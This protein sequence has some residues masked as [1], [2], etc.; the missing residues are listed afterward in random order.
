[1]GRTGS[2]TTSVGHATLDTS[3]ERTHHTPET[4]DETPRTT[5]SHPTPAAQDLTLRFTCPR[6]PYDARLPRTNRAPWGQVQAF[7]RPRSCDVRRQIESDPI[8]IGYQMGAGLRPYGGLK[9]PVRAP[10]G[11]CRV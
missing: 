11:F 5:A 1:M 9:L 10:D 6:E 2:G 3:D 8:C 4:T 7:V